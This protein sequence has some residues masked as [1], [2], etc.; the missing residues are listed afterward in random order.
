MGIRVP[1]DVGD[2]PAD[3]GFRRILVEVCRPES[4]YVGVGW[5][6]DWGQRAKS[7]WRLPLQF[8]GQEHRVRPDKGPKCFAEVSGRGVLR[9]SPVRRPRK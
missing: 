3:A 1:V 8:T 4:A 2:C 6:H 9:T 5:G 7:N